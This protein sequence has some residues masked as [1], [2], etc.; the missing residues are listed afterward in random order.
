[1]KSRNVLQ[2]VIA[3]TTKLARYVEVR[4]NTFWNRSNCAQP[5]SATVRHLVS[6]ESFTVVPVAFWLATGSVKQVLAL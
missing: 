5:H 1:M 2:P 3:F 4:T 6:M